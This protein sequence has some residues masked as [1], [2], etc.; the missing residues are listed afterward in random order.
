MKLFIAGGVG[1]HGRNC[2]FVQGET[3]C[4]LVDCGKMP[5]MPDDLYPHL[6]T[7]QIL[8]L[9]AVFLTHSHADHTG[10]LPWL[11][12]NGFR[13]KV[14]AALETFRQLPFPV[15]DCLMLDELCPAGTGKFQ[16]LAIRWGRSGHCVG[17]V[18]YQLSETGKNI[19]FSG[20]YTENTQVYGCDKIR[21]RQADLA[22]LD[23]AY[24][25]DNTLYAD[26]CNRI[27]EESERLLSD[28][29]LLLFP[30]PKYGRGMEILKLL[31]D[32]LTGIS[33]YADEVF[34]HNLSKWDSESFWYRKPKNKIPV[35]RY[36]GQSQGVIFISDSQLRS[37]AAENTARRV[38]SSGGVPIMTG[39]LEK[40]SYSES[41]YLE[42]KMK[43]LRYPVHLNR[44]QFTYLKEQ[45]NFKRV[46]PYHSEEFSEDREIVF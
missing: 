30:V 12:E 10:A 42:G 44:S 15:K 36:S 31:F 23:C 28:R 9:D 37:K 4:F 41:L 14:I 38:L 20:D 6:S 8:R 5:G 11:F 34:L 2:F 39:T 1:E 43:L 18:W 35:Q 24:G 46:I 7:D 19:L 21:N 13:G 27:V 26:A 45:N 3:C 29:K 22:V 25:S 40:E 17:S 16:G 33:Y 32:H